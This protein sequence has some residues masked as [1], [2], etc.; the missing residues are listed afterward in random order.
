VDPDGLLA[1]RHRGAALD[2]L[3]G[4]LG[5]MASLTVTERSSG[6]TPPRFELWMPLPW[7]AGSAWIP[8]LAPVHVR[9]RAGVAPAYGAVRGG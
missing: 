4:R 5:T 7:S 3:L 6:R 2:A 8:S 1:M 9:H